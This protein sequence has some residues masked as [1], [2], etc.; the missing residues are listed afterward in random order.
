MDDYLQAGPRMGFVELK[1]LEWQALTPEESTTIRV[2]RE[3]ILEGKPFLMPEG[4]R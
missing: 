4:N 3:G 2:L 1:P